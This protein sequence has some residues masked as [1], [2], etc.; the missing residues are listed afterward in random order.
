MDILVVCPDRFT[1]EQFKRDL[2]IAGV[3]YATFCDVLM[4]HLFD[5]IVMT[6]EPRTDYERL[7][8]KEVLSCRLRPDGK[9]LYLL[10]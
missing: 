7:F 1:T 8:V 6:R 9:K 2:P 4:G 10:G 3:M 5:R